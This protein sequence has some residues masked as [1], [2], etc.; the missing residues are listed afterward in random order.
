MSG[1]PSSP[2]ASEAPSSGGRCSGASSVAGRD[3]DLLGVAERALGERREPAQRVDL[4]A[5]QIDAHG[6][7]GGHREDVEQAAAD[8]ELAALLHLVHALVPRRHEVLGAARQ[9]HARARS[10]REAARAQRELG[11]LL[12]ERPRGDHHERWLGTVRARPAECV[13]RRHAQA[14]EVG[15]RAQMRLVADPA[16]GVVAD[17]AR[18]QPRA[19]V[20]REVA[21][22]TVV[23]HDHEHR[24]LRAH[25]R[26]RR[27]RTARARVRQRGDQE[28]AQRRRHVGVAPVLRQRRGVLVRERAG[29]QRAQG[30]VVVA[31]PT[32]G[33]PC[34]IGELRGGTHAF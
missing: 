11:H 22:G 5:E 33:R 19:Q 13:E 9:V 25:R 1:A 34:G 16:R 26:A 18:P 30:T 17:L 6:A 8:R 2:S 12:R 24:G 7:V 23:A 21:R 28:R 27:S 32:L 31:T 10:Q 14:H 20:A 15:G 3:L 29:E 4:V